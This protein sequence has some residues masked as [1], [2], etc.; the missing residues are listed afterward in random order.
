[1]TTNHE[2]VDELPTMLQ[3]IYMSG[4]MDD[5]IDGERTSSERH[6]LFKFMKLFDDA[7]RQ[8]NAALENCPT[9]TESRYKLNDKTGKKIPHQ[10]F[11][12]L[13][14]DTEIEKI[15]H[16][17]KTT[18]YMRWHKDKRLDD[19]VLRHPADGEAWKDLDRLHP[20]FSADP[21]NVRLVLATDGYLACP[22]CNIDASSQS[23]RSK[24]GYMGARRYLLENHNWRRK[25]NICDNLLGTLLSIDGKNKDTDKAR[26]DLEDM[27]IRKELHLI[28]HA[29]GSLQKPPALY[30]LSPV[31]RIGFYDFLQSVKYPDG[32]AT[33]VSNCVTAKGEKNICDNLLGTLLSIDGKNKDTDK[34]RLDL[35]DMRIR[36][37]L[38]LIR[39]ANGSLQKPPALYTLSPVKRIGF[40]DFLQS[41]KYPDGYA[42]NV[43]NCVTAEGGKLVGLKSHDCH[44]LLQRLLP[45]GLQGYL[46]TEIGTTL[47]E[48]GTF[49]KQLCSK[50]L[51]VTDLEKLQEQIVLILCKLE[52]IFPPAFFDVM[53]HL[54][55]HLPYKARLGGPV[56][57]RWMYPIERMLSLLKGFVCNKARPE[58]SIAEAYISKEQRVY[59]VL[60]NM[61]Q[62]RNDNSPEATDEM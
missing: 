39:H 6:N 56:Q 28:R 11:E 62:L 53:V 30:T 43:S 33:N 13:S 24:I 5:P 47:F 25:K 48:F 36:K 3:E 14:L 21:R 61:N 9:C 23:L 58:G 38:H 32:Y 40:Y 27:R 26:L 20:T 8:G 55:I 29:N 15:V 41:V 19:G 57:Y 12:V 4:L 10:N 51:R 7:Q 52:K 31:K 54:A 45:I 2:N 17:Q 50:T 42:T 37:E 59:D 46:P 34:A 16:V 49:F 1:M 35:E 44:V 60:F 18:A 22:N